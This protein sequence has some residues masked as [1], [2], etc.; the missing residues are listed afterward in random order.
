MGGGLTPWAGGEVEH[1]SQNMIKEQPLAWKLNA[2]IWNENSLNKIRELNWPFQYLKIWDSSATINNGVCVFC[3]QHPHLWT[4]NRLFWCSLASVGTCMY[5]VPINAQ[6]HI[7]KTNKSL[8][9]KIVCSDGDWTH[10][11]WLWAG[12]LLFH[13]VTLELSIVELHLS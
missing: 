9:I 1:F 5:V 13:Y 2:N 6:R 3:S 10:S 11:L 12:H 7:N 4:H 8:K